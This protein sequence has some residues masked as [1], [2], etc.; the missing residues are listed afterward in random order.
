[1]MTKSTI[2]PTIHRPEASPGW[3]PRSR[4]AWV[5]LVLGVAAAAWPTL[6]TAAYG[7]FTYPGCFDVCG[8]PVEAG[9]LYAAAA[10]IGVSPFVAVRIY[11]SRYPAPARQRLAAVVLFVVAVAALAGIIAAWLNY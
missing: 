2:P 10:M 3:L 8:S 1:M 7:Y 11:Q 6:V 5:I 4:T 9:A